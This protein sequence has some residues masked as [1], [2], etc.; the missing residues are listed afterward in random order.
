MTQKIATSVL[1]VSAKVDNLED[2]PAE[3]RL[4]SSVLKHG[5]DAYIE[6]DGIVKEE[7]FTDEANQILWKCIKNFFEL[8]ESKPTLS[9][10]IKYADA[11]GY[12]NF[13]EKANE[14]DY[15]K[16]LFNLP[17]E[18]QDARILGT[19]L[20]KLQ[21]KRDFFS[22]LEV[23][24]NKLLEASTLDPLTKILSNVEGPIEDFMLKLVSNDN[25]GCFLSDYADIHMLNLFDNPNTVM[26]I[27]T[28]F[29]CYDD[30]IGGSIE[31]GTFHVI[32]ARSGVGKSI[33][34]AN[35]AI[36]VA[37][38]GHFVI[39]ADLELNAN[40]TINRMIASLS[41]VNGK[42]FNKANF[43]EE[44]KDKINDAIKL[45]KTLPIYYINTSCKGIDETISIFK[46][47]LNKKVGKKQN[48]DFRSCLTIYDYLRLND[49]AELR[50]TLETQ[51][52]GFSA[53]KLK[54]TALTTKVPILTYMQANREG[55]TA[56][57]TG[58]ASGSDR[59]LW[60]CDSMSLF[61]RKD[62]DEMNEDR[63]YNRNFNRKMVWLKARNS[64]DQLPGEYIN[65]N[66]GGDCSLTEG[67]SNMNIRAIQTLKVDNNDKQVQF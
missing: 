45:F 1:N 66:V 13:F 59:V 40:M 2:K 23:A 28:G 54:N 20:R 21:I 50:N 16:G 43:T 53:I 44:E 24:A 32:V 57:T 4:L 51:A 48:N 60:L 27:K 3:G 22:V 12:K 37:K 49:G 17:V 30:M 15:L 61:K 29:N 65:Y 14:K 46:R 42:K 64:E 6:T 36:N 55:I 34:A 31:P 9:S 56:E 52:L 33:H 67:V 7:T 39:L 58:V 38:Q 10:I 8:E 62:E 26:G 41:G 35:T 5:L 25:E 11:L 47:I 18:I 63:A 19:Q